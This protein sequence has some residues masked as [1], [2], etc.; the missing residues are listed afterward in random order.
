MERANYSRPRVFQI[1]IVFSSSSADLAIGGTEVAN[2]N[3]HRPLPRTWQHSGGG[4]GGT[5]LPSVRDGQGSHSPGRPVST[6]RECSATGRN[7]VWFSP[8]S[9]ARAAEAAPRMRAR[10]RK[11]R[12]SPFET[13][14]VLRLEPYKPRFKHVLERCFKALKDTGRRPGAFRSTSQWSRWDFAREA[15]LWVGETKP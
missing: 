6:S 7:S 12:L 11:A 8:E 14:S 10:Q 13:L 15:G 5:P 4:T 1:K 9:F 2:R 3:A